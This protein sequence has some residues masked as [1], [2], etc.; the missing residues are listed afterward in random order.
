VL[1]LLVT[2]LL[3]VYV[4]GPDLVSR[5]ILSFIVPRRA[6]VQSKSE[7]FARA[8]LWS[9]IPLWLAWLWAHHLGRLDA[10]GG[11]GVLQTVFAGLY[12]EPYFSLHRSD[13]FVALAGFSWMNWCLLWRLY[14]M[15]ITVSIGMIVVIRFYGPIR[16]RLDRHE[17]LRSLLAILILPRVSD[18]HVLLSR[19]LLPSKDLR[20]FVDILTKGDN[21]YQGRLADK[22]LGPDGTLVNVILSEPAK[23]QR[24]QYLEAQKDDPLIAPGTFWTKIPGEIF[25][26][27]ASDI[28]T[29]NVR[30]VQS[31]I[32]RQVAPE[33]I[34]ALQALIVK[35]ESSKS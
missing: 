1:P 25:V 23:F 18:W 27:M 8:M 32:T 22:T 28:T 4:L 3:A 24:Q 35:L 7:E 17:S 12:S 13:F 26:I 21:L 15:V 11:A 29:V 20:L 31:R 19:M 9:F 16:R 6:V 5:W 30:Y 33:V 14:L 2:V 10:C 34:K